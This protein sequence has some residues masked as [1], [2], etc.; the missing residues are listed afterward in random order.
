VPPE[1]RHE[2]EMRKL[3]EAMAARVN[4]RELLAKYMRHVRAEEGSTGVAW[5]GGDGRG[6]FSD[7]AFSAEEVA[8]LKACAEAAEGGA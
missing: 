7:V 1:R 5:I 4:Y 6:Y 2:V 3:R 8:A